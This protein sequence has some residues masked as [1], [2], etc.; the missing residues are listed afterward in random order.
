M[1]IF[2]EQCGTI[3]TAFQ[4]HVKERALLSQSFSYWNTYVSDV[5]PIIRDLTNSLRSGD[6]MLYIS[7]V[8]S[9]STLFFLY[10]ENELQSMDTIIFTG[11]LSTEGQVST[12]L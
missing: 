3:Q 7:A 9:A 10:W 11:L 12:P 4:I 5:F 2:K 6:W 8:E 1:E